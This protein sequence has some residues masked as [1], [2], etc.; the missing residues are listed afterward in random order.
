[1]FA[2]ALLNGVG[3]PE[4]T[5]RIRLITTIVNV[6]GFFIAVFFFREIVA[7]AAAYVIRGYLLLPLIMYWVAKYAKVDVRAQFAGLRGPAIA[8]IVMAIAVIAVKLAP[9]GHLAPWVLLVLEVAVGF[10]TFWAALFVVDRP[11]IREIV[12]VGS[13]AIPG[14]GRIARRLG[15]EIP[16]GGRERRRRRRDDDLDN[17]VPAEEMVTSGTSNAA[18]SVG[19]V[20]GPVD[21]AL[22]DV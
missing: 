2:G 19:A 22:G 10:V 14:G 3:H 12:T 5:F 7:V 11:L 13:Q 17:A 1:M 4:V 18:E 15:I 16:E 21:E 8:T 6:T 9:L 20:S